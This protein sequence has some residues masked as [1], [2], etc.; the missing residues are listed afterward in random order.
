L[1][2][3]LADP[4]L[5][6]MTR[7]IALIG[8]EQAQLLDILGPYEVF[9]AANALRR[10][11][12]AREEAYSLTLLG[13]EP[14]T[15]RGENGLSLNVDASL[16]RFRT[17]RAP[18]HTVLVCGG[19]G[20]R[21]AARDPKIVRAVQRLARGAERVASVCTGAFVLAAAGLLDEKRA[22]THWARCEQLA[23]LYPRVVVEAAPIY[24]RDGNVWTSAGVTA[25]IDLALALVEEDL[26]RAVAN[27]IARWLV[28]FVRRAGGQAQFS[29]QLSVQSAER[30]PLRELMAWVVDHPDAQL[31]VPSLAERAHMSVRHFT[32]LFRAETGTSPA[33]YIERVRIETARR[34]LES[35]QRTIEQ[36][37]EA[38]GFGTP[39]ALRRAFARR[40]ELSPREYR[41]RFGVR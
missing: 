37:A 11:Q 6:G 2:Q 7:R 5:E 25:G 26:G 10:A 39:E 38:A 20:A 34:L 33:A 27:E 15:I 40:L 21:K 8:F 30:A 41:A 17:G 9:A 28:V 18:L 35:S 12:G 31:D 24:V 32:R 19:L 14:Q 1:R 16:L 36:V 13:S 4:M 22:T 23:K 3:G 29:A